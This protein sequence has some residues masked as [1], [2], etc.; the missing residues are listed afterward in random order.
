[1]TSMVTD[2]V[3]DVVSGKALMNAAKG[4]KLVSKFQQIKGKATKSIRTETKSMPRCV[5]DTPPSLSGTGRR[6]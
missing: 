3:F 6:Q 5:T 1:M 4:G 2:I